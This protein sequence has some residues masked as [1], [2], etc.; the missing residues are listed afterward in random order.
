MAPSTGRQFRQVF[1]A[2]NDQ[3]IHIFGMTLT[4]LPAREKVTV[5]Q[6]RAAQRSAGNNSAKTSSSGPQLNGD[7]TNTQT[8]LNGGTPASSNQYVLTSTLPSR[9]RQ[10]SILQPSRIPTQ[11][12]ESSYTGLTTFI[13]SLIYL[14]PGHTLAESRLEKH[15]RSLNADDFV[16][17]E[18]TEKGVLARMQREGYIVKVRERGAADAGGEDSVD[19]VVGPRGKLEVGERGVA[20]MVRG[21]YGG[22]DEDEVERRLVRSLGDVVIQKKT[23]G[24]REDGVN[25]HE[26]GEEA[27]VTAEEEGEVAPTERA[28]GMTGVETGRRS[29]RRS[30]GR[31]GR[32]SDEEDEDEED[33]D[34]GD[35]EEEEEEDDEEDEDENEEDE[36]EEDEE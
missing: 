2:A 14:S 21:V 15:L 12:H 26:E 13:V 7:S 24:I 20:G 28:N 17:G 9:Y 11:S 22:N 18:K 10:P 19:F 1:A 31:N 29:S 4:E 6:K 35:E 33:E 30:S 3:L 27:Q 8:N 23:T 25:G 34:E 16:L 32:R 5:A 36:E